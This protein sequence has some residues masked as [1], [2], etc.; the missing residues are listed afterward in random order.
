MAEARMRLGRGGGVVKQRLRFKK[1][2]RQQAR[3]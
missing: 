3:C 2:V 1:L